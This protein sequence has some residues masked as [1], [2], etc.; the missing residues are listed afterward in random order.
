ML[1]KSQASGSPGGCA[2]AKAAMLDRLSRDYLHMHVIM[3]ER[4]RPTMQLEA[5]M[6]T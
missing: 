1:S 3:E 2:A 5:S 6:S 4:M